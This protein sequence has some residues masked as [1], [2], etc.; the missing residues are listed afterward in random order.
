M[1]VRVPL[2]LALASCLIAPLALA[3]ETPAGAAA[4][5][6]SAPPAEA[7]P[8]PVAIPIAEVLPRA[9][10]AFAHLRSLELVAT[11]DAAVQEIAD[12]I[13]ATSEDLI[14]QAFDTRRGLEAARSLDPLREQEMRWHR[15]ERA[16]RGV[17]C[18]GRTAR[19][20]SGCRICG[21]DRGARDLAR[22]RDRRTRGE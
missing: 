1:T 19:R 11:P 8:P 9:D 21:G 14:A 7:S 10:A 5:P 13:R 4:P 18:A 17:V 2:V 3:Q 20:G 15:H 6:A 16:A 12:E 22:D